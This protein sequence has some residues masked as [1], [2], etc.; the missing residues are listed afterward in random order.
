MNNKDGGSQTQPKPSGL[1]GAVAGEDGW[2]MPSGVELAEFAVQCGFL[3]PHPLAGREER[4][5]PESRF[6]VGAA[7]ERETS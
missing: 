5:P 7:R 1:P 2:S 3:A 6:C 4:R